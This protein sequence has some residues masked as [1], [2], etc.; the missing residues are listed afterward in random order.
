MRNL[1]IINLFF[2][3]FQQLVSEDFSIIP[4]R[5]GVYFEFKTNSD[6]ELEVLSGGNRKLCY[7]CRNDSIVF[8]S[9]PKTETCRSHGYT[10]YKVLYDFIHDLNQ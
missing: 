7:V 5:G 9:I 6:F 10:D 1:I 3:S 8:K 2:I 4:R